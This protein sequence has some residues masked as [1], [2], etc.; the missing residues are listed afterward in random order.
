MRAIW[1]RMVRVA[2]GLRLWDLEELVQISSGRLSQIER[3]LVHPKPEELVR[4]ASAL[5]VPPDWLLERVGG[6][7]EERRPVLAANITGTV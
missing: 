4:S 5:D 2:S 7:R 1:M 3:G 6:R